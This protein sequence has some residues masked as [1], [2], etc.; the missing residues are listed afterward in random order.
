MN[1]QIS[2]GTLFFTF[3]L[4]KVT[5]IITW[6]WWWITSP[7]WLPFALVF[8][9]VLAILGFSIGIILIAIV[10]DMCSLKRKVNYYGK[11]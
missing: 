3:L 4:L 2:G 1:I 5:G 6:S 7:L 9:F 10:A 8:A 11:N